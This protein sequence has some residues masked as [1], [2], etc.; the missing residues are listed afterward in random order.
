MQTINDRKHA[1]YTEL[2]EAQDNGQLWFG[3][4]YADGCDPDERFTQMRVQNPENE[5][6]SMTAWVPSV[7]ASEL[8]LELGRAQRSGII[9]RHG[10]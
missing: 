9:Q 10:N 1:T 6:W 3:I 7:M 5:Q 4:L 2:R 8:A